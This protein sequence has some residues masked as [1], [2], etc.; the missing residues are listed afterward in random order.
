MSH[1]HQPLP[2]RKNLSQ[3]EEELLWGLEEALSADIDSWFSSSLACCDACF[4][5][6]VSKWPLAYT[7]EDGLQYTQTP[8][9]AFYSGS[10]R[11][12]SM[13]TEKQFEKLLPY[14]ECPNCGGPL[15][16]NLFSFELPFDPEVFGEDL[17]N[18]GALA[19]T[20]PFLLLTNKFA[21]QI[22]SEIENLCSEVHPDRP[23]E[24]FYRGRVLLL[25][26]KQKRDFGPPPASD[27]KEGRYN[28]AGC[29]ALYLANNR[30]TCW[31]ECRRPRADF[32]V[33]SFEFKRAIK[34]LDLSAPEEMTDVMAALMYSNLTAAPSDRNG[35]DRPEYVLTRFVGDCA[36]ATGVDAILYLSTRVG[37]GTNLALLDGA[38]YSKFL[39]VLRFEDYARC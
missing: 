3:E 11:V 1:K 35:W 15:G 4:D 20:A 22:Q 38:Q 36:R 34:I 7:K 27:T 32:F 37:G 6:Y 29:P 19:K 5:D 30:A 26:T 28:H 16:P 24:V 31:E 21:R 13:V 18:L 23:S 17:R 2:D 9:D 8:A 10:R 39:R 33:A 25:R 14:I 12:Q